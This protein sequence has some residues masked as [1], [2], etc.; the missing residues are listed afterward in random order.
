MTED[1]SLC[2]SDSSVDVTECVELVLFAVAEHVVLLDSVQGLLFSLKLDDVG[3]WHNPLCKFP[4]RVLKGGR[5]DSPLNADALVLVSLCG[6]HHIGLVQ[7]KHF[8]LFGV[9]ELQLNAPVQNRPRC[10]DDD[11]LLDLNATLHWQR[12]QHICQFDFWI[13]LAHLLNDFPRLQS[14]LICGRNA[15]TLQDRHRLDTK[16]LTTFTL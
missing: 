6:D 1:H 9:D 14:Q 12:A 7:N 11:L 2:D 3:I 4:H 10:A 15:Q 16:V 13:K 5:E 8:D